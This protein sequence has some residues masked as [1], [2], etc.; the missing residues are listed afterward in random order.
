MISPWHVQDI[1]EPNTYYMLW[2]AFCKTCHKF[3]QSWL[4]FSNETFVVS[5]ACIL[6]P[7]VMWF[8]VSLNSNDHHYTGISLGLGSAN[9]KMRYIVMPPLIGWAHSQNYPCYNIV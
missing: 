7:S 9:E 5:D 4:A 6:C 1:S 8:I 2:L 3:C